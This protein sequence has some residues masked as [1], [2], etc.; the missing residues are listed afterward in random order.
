M[1]NLTVMTIGFFK[2]TVS[3]ESYPVGPPQ[4]TE[5]K[6]LTCVEIAAIVF[7]DE[8]RSEGVHQI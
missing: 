1:G 6:A 8:F 4:T 5:A 3:R 2:S 7:L